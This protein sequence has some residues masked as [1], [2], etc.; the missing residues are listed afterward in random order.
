[1]PASLE[2]LLSFQFLGFCMWYFSSSALK[3]W[4]KVIEISY[5]YFVQLRVYGLNIFAFVPVE[6]RRKELGLDN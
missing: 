1:M 5:N 3:C 4:S 2:D 6:W